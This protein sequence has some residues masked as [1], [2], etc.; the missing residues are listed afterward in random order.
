MEIQTAPLSDS[1]VD[2]GRRRVLGNSLSGFHAA[3][4]IAGVISTER[5]VWFK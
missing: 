1:P 2:R 3:F 4:F 5:T